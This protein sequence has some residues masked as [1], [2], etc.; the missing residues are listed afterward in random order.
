MFEQTLKQMCNIVD[1]QNDMIVL[2]S[3]I[4][5]LFGVA[6]L[7]SQYKGNGTAA[8]PEVLASMMF[9]FAPEVNI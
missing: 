4:R 2:W 8:S 3:W 5:R 1:I 7:W 9:A 6:K